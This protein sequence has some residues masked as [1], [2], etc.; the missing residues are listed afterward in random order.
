MKNLITILLITLG[1]IMVGY[2]GFPYGC[3]PQLGFSL[4]LET[5]L[6]FGLIVLGGER[7]YSEDKKEQTIGFKIKKKKKK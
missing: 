1:G 7:L 5:L 3:G 2:Y 6:G 4:G